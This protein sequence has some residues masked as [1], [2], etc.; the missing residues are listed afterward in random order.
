MRPQQTH[1]TYEQKRPLATAATLPYVCGMQ[2]HNTNNTMIFRVYSYKANSTRQLST[3]SY[4][5]FYFFTFFVFG[6]CFCCKH[7]PW[8]VPVLILMT[9]PQQIWITVRMWVCVTVKKY[10]LP[11]FDGVVVIV[12]D[13]GVVVQPKLHFMAN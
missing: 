6:C 10:L 1:P 5:L 11:Y 8:M 12:V 9:A 3:L 2:H 4:L 7:C 13:G